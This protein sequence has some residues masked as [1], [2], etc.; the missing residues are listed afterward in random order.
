M[1]GLPTAPSSTTAALQQK[2]EDK[3]MT[4]HA[5]P[6][7]PDQTSVEVTPLPTVN[8]VP[9]LAAFR[10]LDEAFR[11]LR[12]APGPSLTYGL[13]FTAVCIG[14]LALARAL[15]WFP[16]A[17]LTGLMLI[18]PFMAAGLYTAARQQEAG[19]PVS[20]ADGVRLL[21]QRSSDLGLFAIFL[22]LIMAAWVRFSA[23]LFAFQDSMLQPSSSNYEALISGSLDHPALLA[24]FVLIGALLAVTVFVSS[25]VAIPMILDRGV[26]PLAAVHASARAVTANWAAMLVWA[27]LIVILSTVGIA[28]WMLGMILVFPLLGYATWRS[29]RALLG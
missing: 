23:L 14:V 12:T 2:R 28:T 18:G 6:S 3:P 5:T 1:I 21:W 8:K 16:I 13:L 9:P 24:F 11:V 29:Y 27:G 4:T 15:P 17:L 25:A 7:S 26:G 10:W 22:G 20:I 19:E